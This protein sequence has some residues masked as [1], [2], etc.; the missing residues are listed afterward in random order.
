MN[1]AAL[2]SLLWTKEARNASSFKTRQTAVLILSLLDPAYRP[3]LVPTLIL[4]MAASLLLAAVFGNC[5]VFAFHR[6]RLVMWLNAAT[7]VIYLV[8]TATIRDVGLPVFAGA[9]AGAV[10]FLTVG[11]AAWAW[12]RGGR[13]LPAAPVQDAERSP[14]D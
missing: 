9:A 7:A 3:A 8:A 5:Y 6:E 2:R 13:P 11:M 14:G 12:P 1:S 10:L 4:L